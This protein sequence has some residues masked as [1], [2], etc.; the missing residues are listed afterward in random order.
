MLDLAFVA[1]GCA[2]IGLMIAYAVALRQL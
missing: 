2:V 1:L